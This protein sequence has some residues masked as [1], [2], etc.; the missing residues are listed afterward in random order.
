LR[1]RGDAAARAR[2]RWSS[3]RRDRPLQHRR[4]GGRAPRR[5]G[6]AV[7]RDFSATPLSRKLGAKPGVAVLVFFTTSRS[8]LE[9]R[10]PVLQRTL[11]GPDGLWV[12]W[13]KR[14]SGIDTDLSF[15]AVQ[16]IGLAAGLVDN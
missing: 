10:F 13:P 7:R 14:S 2:G 6:G 15:E 8:E 12:A 3:A 5:A 9:R 1:P 11:A 4:G 16:E